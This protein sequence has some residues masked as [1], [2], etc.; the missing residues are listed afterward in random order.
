MH[1]QQF[2]K[3]G[4]LEAEANLTRNNIQF[5][6]FQNSLDCCPK[7]AQLFQHRRESRYTAAMAFCF[8]FAFLL[9]RSNQ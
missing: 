2:H 7:F 3:Q 5:K 8:S 6:D 4:P 1:L 9:A